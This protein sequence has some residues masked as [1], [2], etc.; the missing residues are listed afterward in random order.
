MNG[1]LLIGKIHEQNRNI[2]GESGESSEDNDLLDSLCVRRGESVME[3]LTQGCLREGAN[4]L[5]KQGDERG[6]LKGTIVE[7]YCN[8]VKLYTCKYCQ[9]K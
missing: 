8:R 1:N 5:Q 2:V 9:C 4:V 7:R 6:V 3:I